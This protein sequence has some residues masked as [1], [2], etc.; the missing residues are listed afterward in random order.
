MMNEPFRIEARESFRVIG[1]CVHTTNKRK[2]GRKA[3]PQQWE[4]LQ[5]QGLQKELLQ[6]MNKEPFGLFGISVYNTAAEDSRKFDHW[7]AVSSDHACTK[8]QEEYIVP[9]A[10]WAV[11]PC[12]IDTIGKTEVQA[13]TKWLPKSDYRPLNSGYITGRMKAKAPD[14]TYYGENDLAEVW[15]AVEKR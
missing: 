11:F 14:I 7:I 9:A 6:L 3:I 2:E 10:T 4:E 15:V 12:T 8:A 13:I 5:T 1:Y